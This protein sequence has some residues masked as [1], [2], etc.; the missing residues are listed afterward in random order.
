MNETYGIWGQRRR[1]FLYDHKRSVFKAMEFE[2]TLEKHLAE[3]D[4]TANEMFSQLV[5]E[6]A[7]REGVTEDL[8]AQDQIAWVGAMNNIRDRVN[9]IICNELIYT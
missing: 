9:E 1:A 6:Y 8:K 7:A 3:T 4:K 2:G 5:K